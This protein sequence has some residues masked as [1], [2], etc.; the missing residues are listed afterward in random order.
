VAPATA[1][2]DR[3]NVQSL[4]GYDVRRAVLGLVAHHLKPSAFK[5]ARHRSATARSE[6][7]R[8]KSTRAAGSIR[9]SRLSRPRRP[10][11]LFRDGLVPRARPALGV[12][13]HPPPP[14][15]MGRHLIEL[16]YRL[17][18]GWVEFL[19]QVYERQLD[20]RY[21]PLTRD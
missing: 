8:R 4:D 18:P 7:S 13:H 6:G 21:R 1:L 20:G 19:R 11:R 16:G 9:Q 12:E 15:L 2:L 10:L 5:K 17:A 14:L 3:W